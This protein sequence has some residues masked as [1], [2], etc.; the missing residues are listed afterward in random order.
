MREWERDGIFENFAITSGKSVLVAYFFWLFFFVWK[1]GFQ[2]R[3][4]KN[5]RK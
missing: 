2:Q 1:K 5:F 4:T 3:V